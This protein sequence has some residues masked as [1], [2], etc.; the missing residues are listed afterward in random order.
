L[1]HQTKNPSAKE[2]FASNA[3]EVDGIVGGGDI[4]QLK[5]RLAGLLATNLVSDVVQ[6]EHNYFDFESIINSNKILL[7]RVPKQSLGNH[8]TEFLG[9]M[10]LL[11]LHCVAE[12]QREKGLTPP[13]PYYVYIDEFQNFASPSFAKFIDGAAKR[14][15]SYTL[16][17]QTLGQ[18][19]SDMVR[20]MREGI[21]NLISFQL[22]GTDAQLLGE[23]LA[24]SFGAGDVM[25][26]GVRQFYIRM[27]VDSQPT[28]PFSGETDFV[29]YP[30]Q[31]FA[32][33]IVRASRSKVSD[34]ERG[35][36]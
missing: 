25:N 12:Y 14:G 35:G 33:A 7:V 24:P 9:S 21:Q 4:L 16:S 2:Y 6:Q 17:H 31:N 30:E 36:S 32:E 34:R 29:S 5:I 15:L 10:V 18:I 8:N 27:T 11:M 22:G 26:L 1:V 28:A 20:A 13:E 23:A 19:S 3:S